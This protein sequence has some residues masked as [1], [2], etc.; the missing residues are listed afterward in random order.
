MVLVGV[1][2]GVAQETAYTVREVVIT[3]NKALTRREIYDALPFNIGARIVLDD[4]EKGAGVLRALGTLEK[5]EGDYRILKNGIRVIYRVVENPVV[6]K[7]EFTG[8]ES[9]QFYL[10]D[11]WGVKLFPYK[12]RLARRDELIDALRD[13]KIE[14]NKA[15]NMKW[16]D[17]QLIE[18]AITQFYLK[19]GYTFIGVNP[20]FNREKELLTIQI[21]EGK[22]EAFEIRGLQEVPESL[23][24]PMLQV[25]VGE[26]VKISPIQE[27]IKALNRSVYF[28]QADENTLGIEQ[29]SKPDT[30]KIT[31]NLKERHL[32]DEPTELRTIRLTGATVYPTA[33]LHALIGRLPEGP[34][35]NYALLTA[36]KRVFDIYR[37]DGY[38]L[39]NFVQESLTD[40]TLTV[41]ITEGRIVKVTITN[42]C[43]K[44]MKSTIVP[45][46]IEF[47][48]QC[49]SELVI[50][51]ELRMKEGDL[52][53]ENP[54][55]D[56]FRNLMQL[57]YFKQDGV[58]VQPKVLDEATGE[59]EL[60]VSVVEEEQLGNVKGGVSYNPQVGLVG[61]VS[62][63]WK[64]I[65]GTAQ[66][67]DLSLDRGLVGREVLNY[68]VSYKTRGY[69]KEYNSVDVSL[70]NTTEQQADPEKHNM[71]KSGATFSLSYPLASELTLSLRLRY[72][73][74]WRADPIN[75]KSLIMSLGM[76]LI[77]DTRN[78]PT[79]PT[80]G[81]QW[82]LMGEQAG[83]F[84]VGTEFTK[85]QG[86]WAYHWQTLERQTLSVRLYGAFGVTLP[87]QER[88][89]FGGVMTVR[90]WGMSWTNRFG[91]SNLEYRMELAEN[92]WG[93]FYYD[94]GWGEG[95]GWHQSVGFEMRLVTPFI[96]NVRFV[97]AWPFYETGIPITPVFQFGFGT[98]F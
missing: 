46:L 41:H 77:R 48:R 40:E 45:N 31:W 12:L 43:Q 24:K 82:I 53:N 10:I 84:A 49:T 94:A 90:G 38:L 64:N 19:K 75:E 16:F 32:L 98:M 29:G 93:V 79:F 80:S 27:A 95:V 20:V 66:D 71:T 6:K 47:P 55:R 68:T 52:V 63:G 86:I 33:R 28:H 57:G 30:V 18:N 17:D 26:P 8:N 69:F 54:L 92:V 2:L 74:V 1:V 65:L 97:L 78:N 73:D 50:R 59:V 60:L 11:I 81:G 14:E 96:G 22:L 76:D 3:G 56:S 70:F 72:E 4:V 89:G 13:A 58:N 91:L 87:A 23:V 35:D 36:L 37:I 51:K 44:G 15:L 67:V 5:V 34:V 61:Q 62:L 9:Y 85:L 83:K 88:F 7:I 21:V 39:V 25:P 42:P